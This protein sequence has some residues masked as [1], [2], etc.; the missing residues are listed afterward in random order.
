MRKSIQSNK[1]LALL[2]KYSGSLLSGSRFLPLFVTQFFSALNDNVYKQAVL[3]LLVFQAASVADGALYSNLAAGLFILPFFLFSGMA[4]QLAEKTEKSKLIRVVKLF[5]I[6]IMVVG[7]I[8]IMTQLI[9]LMLVTVFLMGLQSTFFGP[10]KYSILPQHVAPHELTKANGLVESGTFVA[11]LLGT[12]FGTY[13]ITQEAGPTY[14][15]IAILCLA[16]IGYLCSRFIP[17][18]EANDRSLKF[19]FNIFSSTKS[20]FSELNSQSESVR[21]SVIGISW[22]W[23]IG[24]IILTALPNYVK[25]VL[26]GDELVVTTALVVFSLSIALGS[27]LCDKLSRSRIE[28]GI[29]PF[30][31]ILITVFLYL[32]SQEPAITA[33]SVP[34]ETLLTLRQVIDTGDMIWHLI[35]MAGIGISAGF[36]TVPLYALIQQ[37]TNEKSRSR[38]IAANNV[39]NALFMVGSALLSI[40]TLSIFE[41]SISQLM[42]LLAGLNFLVSIYIYT[43]VPEFFLRFVIYMLAICMYRVRTRGEKNI[44]EEGA[45]VLVG[46]HVSFVDWMFIL[47]ASP[48]LV[49]FVVFAPIYYSPAL[50]WLFK[51]AKAIPIESEKTNPKVFEKAL[52]DIAEAL[53]RGE[54]VGIF[55]EGKLS[56]DG[57]IDVFR[58]GVETIIKRTPVPVIPV[59]L[60]GLWGSMFSRKTKW[61]LP[62]LRWSLV[63]ISIGE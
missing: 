21:K 2:N 39:L 55:P 37:R 35:W 31:A 8:S 28:L 18:S 53:K 25:Y 13:Y 43:K 54:L 34:T 22:F 38:V 44:P 16:V 17:I 6:P 33:Y 58:Q 50:H 5:E 20:V 62:R 61:R 4:G 60:S 19:T 32:L 46:N 36:Y 49:R 51:V 29:V 41:W 7:A 10:L 27:L 59:H 42:L 3:L 24:A 1:D 26:G 14:I 52:D 57:S 56:A 23:L 40:V 9:W 12:V 30:G 15:S 63:S 47:A 48:R 45:A 11:I